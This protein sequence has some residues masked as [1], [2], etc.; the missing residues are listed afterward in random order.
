MIIDSECVH[1]FI[2][3]ITIKEEGV[4]KLLANNLKPHEATGPHNIP[5]AFKRRSKDLAP[6]I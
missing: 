5:T 2:E 1:V 4:R 3:N 6:S